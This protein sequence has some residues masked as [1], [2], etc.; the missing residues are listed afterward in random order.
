MINLVLWI[1]FGAIVGWLAS[2]VMG[3]NRRQGMLRDIVI[4][5]AGAFIGGW[6]LGRDISNNLFS[7][8]SI[9]TALVGAVVLLALVNLGTRGRLR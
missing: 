1:V 2:L 9:I 7:L 4:G 8:P 5:I 3:S 6:L